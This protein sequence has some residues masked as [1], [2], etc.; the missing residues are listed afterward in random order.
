M[1]DHARE[2][3]LFPRLHPPPGGVERLRQGLA[4]AGEERSGRF[5]VLLL[6]GFVG[7]AAVAALMVQPRGNLQGLD[8]ALQARLAVHQSP[9]SADGSLVELPSSD[10]RVRVYMLAA[11]PQ[12]AD[13]DDGDVP[14]PPVQQDS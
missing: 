9:R 12:A 4:E 13:A 3:A 6:A 5:T 10:P 8:A 14:Q 2:R 1:H 7:C 11:T